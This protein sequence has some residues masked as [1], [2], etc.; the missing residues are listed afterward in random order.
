MLLLESTG[1]D[2]S[3]KKNLNAHTVCIPSNQEDTFSTI[4]ADSTAIGTQEKTLSVSGVQ[5][6][7]HI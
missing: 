5:Y 1:L 2:S 7:V 3:L 6:E 4:V